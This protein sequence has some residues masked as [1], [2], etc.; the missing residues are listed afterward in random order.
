MTDDELI[1]L[2]REAGASRY[3][4]RHY[5]DRP[6]HTFNLGGLHRFVRLVMD[7]EGHAS[8]DQRKG[9]KSSAAYSGEAFQTVRVGHVT[10]Q[11]KYLSLIA[12]LPD[13]RIGLGA[14]DMEPAALTFTGG[15]G[16]VMPVRA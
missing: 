14:N 6:T 1:A 11:R 16:A 13:C 10:F 8:V 3:T 15:F 2:A 12:S 9:H 7:R 4:N 5:P